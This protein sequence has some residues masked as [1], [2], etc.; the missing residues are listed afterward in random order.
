M[1]LALASSSSGCSD[2]IPEAPLSSE[3]ALRREG[4]WR[5]AARA[6]LRRERTLA[7]CRC[8]AREMQALRLAPRGP[9][10]RYRHSVDGPKM[11]RNSVGFGPSEARG[12]LHPLSPVATRGTQRVLQLLYLAL[13]FFDS[14]PTRILL[15]F[16]SIPAQFEPTV[17]S[18]RNVEVVHRRRGNMAV[19]TAVLIRFA[20]PRMSGVS[21]LRGTDG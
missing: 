12:G 9:P 20:H 11:T 4:P 7:A 18:V 10:G 3:Y 8:S 19:S 15:T 14:N 1:R 16:V 21:R 17:G 2:G 5:S 13:R 6:G